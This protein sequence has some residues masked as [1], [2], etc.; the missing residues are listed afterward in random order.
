MTAAGDSAC[1]YETKKKSKG[2]RVRRKRE[3]EKE[4]WQQQEEYLQEELL[5]RKGTMRD[6]YG[7]EE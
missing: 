1:V 7:V 6:W 4:R 3:R 2:K 5:R